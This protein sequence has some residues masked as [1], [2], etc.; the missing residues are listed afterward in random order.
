MT[1][2]RA[3]MPSSARNAISDPS[4]RVAPSMSAASTPPTRATGRVR[5]AS[6]ARRQLLK[7]A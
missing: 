1:P 3:A 6:P 2:L 4:E 5:K 7:A